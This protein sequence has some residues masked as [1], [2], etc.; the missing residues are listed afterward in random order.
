L[1][2]NPRRPWPNTTAAPFLFDHSGNSHYHSLQVKLERR[3]ANGLTFR[4]SYTWSKTMDVDSDPVMGALEYPYDRRRSWGPALF[5]V[6]HVNSTALVYQLPFGRGQKYASSA[7]RA[8]DAFV[9]GWQLSGII[10]LRSGQV[11]QIITGRDSAN[12]G[13]TLAAT[14]QRADIVSSPVPS[15]FEQRRE[16]WF[17]PGAF[18]LPTFG[19]LGSH[20]RNSMTGPA[21]QNFDLA[22]AKDFLINE[23]LLLEFRA[24]FFNAFNHTNFG[25]PVASLASPLLGQIQGAF[26]ARDVQM[27][28]KLRW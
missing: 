28:L 23:P 25:N 7:P 12:T 14:S 16:R 27:A 15:G 4:N 24:E 22:L 6:P 13:H 26:A 17:D 19:T 18:R 2:I 3:F 21:V 9:G 1:P 10:S 8:V 5:H 11:Y 20:S